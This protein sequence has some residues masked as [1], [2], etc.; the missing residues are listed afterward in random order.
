MLVT[1]ISDEISIVLKSSAY[2]RAKSMTSFYKSDLFM[3]NNFL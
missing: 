3:E 1:M 2:L